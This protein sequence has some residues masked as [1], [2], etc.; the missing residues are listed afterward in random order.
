MQAA[1]KAAASPRFGYVVGASSYLA[2]QLGLMLANCLFGFLLVRM[3]AK[4]DYAWFTIAFVG[5][6]MI[7]VLAD[8][9]LASALTSIGGSMVGDR[10]KIAGLSIRISKWRRTFV[11]CAA[12]VILPCLCFMLVSSGATWGTN[13]CVLA[14]VAATG[15]LSIES[16]FLLS[17]QKLLGNIQSV[18]AAECLFGFLRLVLLLPLLFIPTS[19]FAALVV[20]FIAQVIQFGFLFVATRESLGSETFFDSNWDKEIKGKVQ[21]VIPV[22]IWHCLQG[23]ATTVLLAVFATSSQVADVG[24]MGRFG[25]AFNFVMIPLGHFFLPRIARS[26]APAE[27]FKNVSTTVATFIGLIWTLVLLGTVSAPWLLWLLGPQYA[28]LRME[29]VWYLIATAIAFSSN[30]FWSIAL[31][32]GWVQMAWIDI[33][34][35]IGLQVAFLPFLDLQFVSSAILFG[36][37]SS[38]VH[39]IVGIALVMAG[40]R[41][42]R[43]VEPSDA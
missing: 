43:S 6:T 10:A 38:F 30:V 16:S 8:S 31:T 5:Q 9:G 29:L 37:L 42:I 23:Q 28:N 25:I 1:K 15:A 39:L 35:T 20:T 4:A 12:L 22:S 11:S 34:L 17:I 32:R 36:A 26:I 7:S 3:L 33:A 21:Q 19:V 2:I 27:L 24:A 13:I 41:P 40:L 14:F 18:I